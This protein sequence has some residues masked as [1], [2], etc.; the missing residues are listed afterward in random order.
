MADI[1]PPLQWGTVEVFAYSPFAD[2]ADVGDSP[3]L[4]GLNGTVY[5]RPLVDRWKVVDSMGR[6]L[7]FTA[8]TVNCRLINGIIYAPDEAELLPVRLLASRTAGLS[9]GLDAVQY[10][11]TITSDVGETITIPRFEIPVD[12]TVNLADKLDYN[13]GAV[14]TVISEQTRIEAEAAQAA[15]EVARDAAEAAALNAAALILGVDDPVPGTTPPGR[16]I[17]RTE[18]IVV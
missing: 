5:I 2:S 4:I 9:G 13:V 12:G 10:T 14:L 11:A 1:P 17:L 6:S 16:L 8:R 7:L 3:D 15:A 18:G